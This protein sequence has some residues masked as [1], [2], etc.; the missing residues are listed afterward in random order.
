MFLFQ[1]KR[2]QKSEEVGYWRNA[3]AIH[4]WFIEN[5][6][7][8]NDDCKTYVVPRLKLQELKDTC[9][10]VL[11][12]LEEGGF[13]I[14]KE[15]DWEDKDIDVTIYQNTKL[16]EKLLPTCER[17]D[18]IYKEDLEHTIEICN[19]CL[20]QDIPNSKFYYCSWW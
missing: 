8:G 4:D 20:S 16:A 3:D 13:T 7:K 1:K 12:S 18:N 2:W 17:Y 19:W 11:K 10:K 14:H 15:K 5:V 9:E 6:Q